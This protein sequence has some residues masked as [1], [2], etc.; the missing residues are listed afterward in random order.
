MLVS[1][2]AA[3]GSAGLFAVTTNLQRE[4]AARVPSHGTGPLHLVRRLLADPRWLAGGVVGVVALGLHALALARGSVL[5]VQSVMALGLVV[6]LA[7]EARRAHRPLY[8]NELG[9]AAL[10]VGGVIVV[11][12]M[13]E[14]ASGHIP[15]SG[16]IVPVCA[17]VVAGAFL[18]V[19]WSRRAVGS[20]WGARL[21]GAAGGACFAVD[22]VFLQRLASAVDGGLAGAG[23]ADAVTA[24][25]AALA[26]NLVG[27]L[28]A[29][30]VGG[31]AVHRAYQVAPLRT[32]QPALAAAE[33]VTAFLV[34]ALVL[35]E[36]VR[37]GALGYAVLVGGLVAITIGIV[38]GLGGPR[39]AQPEDGL[40]VGGRDADAPAVSVVVPLPGEL[41][42]VGLQR[43]A[44]LRLQ[45]G[46][47]ADRRPVPAPEEVHEVL[48]RR[49]P[50]HLDLLARVDVGN[51]VP[52][53]LDHVLLGAP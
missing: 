52:E 34:S 23:L 36:G 15:T 19:V 26:A 45:R 5:A 20:T 6:A 51:G 37:A 41:G 21:L 49:V 8:P 31:V 11:V 13:G 40:Q 9:G 2:V 3:L 50:E 27:F 29:A 28:T 47:R 25:P 46:E 30:L 1:I 38:V 24:A 32:V 48:G 43:V 14:P 12:G 17:A 53:K 33:P 44:A 10:V 4:A 39:S 35:H 16:W 18:A 42:Q 22:A 7:L